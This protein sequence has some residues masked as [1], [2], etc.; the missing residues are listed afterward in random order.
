MHTAQTAGEHY[1]Q[2]LALSR[3]VNYRRSLEDVYSELHSLAHIYSHPS[4]FTASRSEGEPL[5]V[6][7]SSCSF[8]CCTTIQ[9]GCARTLAVSITAE[10]YTPGHALNLFHWMELAAKSEVQD[11]GWRLSVQVD[12][13]SPDL[14]IIVV[15]TLA[16]TVDG[17]GGQP[18]R[19]KYRTQR[20][21][22]ESLLVYTITSLALGEYMEL[23]SSSSN[24][25]FI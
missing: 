6:W 9:C 7:P 21:P 14:P 23:K 13:N 8:R 12:P 17:Q 25:D 24:S 18:K 10:E 11:T 2:G 22:V 5:E 15:H 16:L 19:P 20:L 4:L 1:V 3:L